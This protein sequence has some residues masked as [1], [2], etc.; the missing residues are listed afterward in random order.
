VATPKVNFFILGVAYAQNE[1]SGIFMII[2][3][4]QKGE[5]I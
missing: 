1:I 3:E 5:I 4:F 2:Q